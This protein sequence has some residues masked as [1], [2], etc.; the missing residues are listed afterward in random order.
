MAFRGNDAGS[1]SSGEP[2]AGLNMDEHL[3]QQRAIEAWADATADTVPDSTVSTHSSLTQ[4]PFRNTFLMARF[5]GPTWG[6]S[7]ADRAQVG[8][9]LAP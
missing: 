7:G 1:R 8:P 5:M 6:P 9:M 4:G 3:A 2:I